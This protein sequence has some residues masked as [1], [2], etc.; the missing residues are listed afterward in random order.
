MF[1]PKKEKM[2]NHKHTGV[3]Q[4]CMAGE[5]SPVAKGVAG[6]KKN[7]C[8]IDLLHQNKLDHHLFVQIFSQVFEK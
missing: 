6:R 2:G 4:P 3:L 8:K 7:M 5:L 1:Q